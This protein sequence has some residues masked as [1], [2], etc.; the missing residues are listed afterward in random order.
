MPAAK[1]WFIIVGASG[2]LSV[3]LGAFGAHG[4][5]GRISDSLLAAF[6][7]GTQYQMF[8]TLALFGLSVL[9]M[10]L[11]TVPKALLMS[12]YCWMLGML[13]FSGSLYGLAL[14]GP[15]WLGPITPLGGL[16]LILGW[17][18]LLFGSISF[19]S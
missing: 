12:G 15:S 2:F 17:I 8:H 1:W 10:Q 5:K 13:L 16:L 6:Q 9:I 7:T 4:L 3:A 14:G 19:G 18:F 11:S